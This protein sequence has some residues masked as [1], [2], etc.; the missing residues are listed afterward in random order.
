MS[1]GCLDPSDELK[2]TT[3][4]TARLWSVDA[5]S[6]PA[7]AGRGVRRRAVRAVD[8]A[9][10]QGL[11]TALDRESRV[12]QVKAAR[13]RGDVA[14]VTRDL[15]ERH[16]DA[17]AGPPPQA[18]GD[19]HQLG[20]RAPQGGNRVV[21]VVVTG[22]VVLFLVAAGFIG[23]VFSFVSSVDSEPIEPV[24]PSQTTGPNDDP[25]TRAG[26]EVFLAD[27]REQTG[28]TLVTNAS[29]SE[30]LVRVDVA[31][32]EWVTPWTLR[33]GS[34]ESSPRTPR[35]EWHQTVDLAELEPA[36]LYRQALDHGDLREADVTSRVI[37]VG[38][39]E[40]SVRVIVDV[41]PTVGETVSLQLD[42][43]E[44]TRAP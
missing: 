2:D 27:L 35:G 3:W 28:A 19:A 20:T 4:A 41:R 22:V 30:S 5:I 40:D 37:Y 7:S 39:R 10:A 17:P 11:I 36:D 8:N 43:D 44:A 25:M 32:G 1:P 18:A 31:D 34:W 23:F 6:N 38:K 13:T 29:I 21:G 16:G 26:W 42:G 15:Q 33:D 9:F 24:T 12:A 14:M